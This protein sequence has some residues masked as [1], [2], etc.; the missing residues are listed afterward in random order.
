MHVHVHVHIS[1]VYVKCFCIFLENV[2]R[3]KNL[4]YLNLALNNI[5]KIENLSGNPFILTSFKHDTIQI[6][7]HVVIV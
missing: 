7:I 5:T 6:N 4:E 2:N 1:H 3:L